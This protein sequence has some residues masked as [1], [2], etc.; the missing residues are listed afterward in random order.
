M[1][2][3][4]GIE[5]GLPSVRELAAARGAVLG[6]RW[7]AGRGARGIARTLFQ[8]EPGFAIFAFATSPS[9]LKM[10]NRASRRP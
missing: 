4:A 1:R 9:L 3:Q 7:R 10:G 8:R 6:D 2:R 5:P